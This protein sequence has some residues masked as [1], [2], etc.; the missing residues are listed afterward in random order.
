MSTLNRF[1][2]K[3]GLLFFGI[4]AVVSLL[5]RAQ[6]Y[7]DSD[8]RA[9]LLP[10]DCESP[11]FMGIRPGITTM[12]E[13]VTLLEKHEWVKQVI[14]QGMIVHWFWNGREPAFLDGIT[15][16]SL[17]AVVINKQQVVGSM[18]LPTTLPAGFIYLLIGRPMSY[19]VDPS[20]HLTDVTSAHYLYV[21]IWFDVLAV[22][23]AVECPTRLDTFWHESGELS[24]VSNPVIYHYWSQWDRLNLHRIMY[25]DWGCR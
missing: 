20:N 25:H 18:R 4:F 24:L 13:A 22:S 11:C 23:A 10:S 9:L 8:L 16:P 5:I 3:L 12:D 21:S 15:A 6:P 1:Y 2:L 17:S 19:R 14:R 7:D